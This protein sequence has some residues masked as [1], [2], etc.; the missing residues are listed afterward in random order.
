MSRLGELENAIV[1]RLAGAQIGGEDAFAVVR[2]ESGGFRAALRDT[3][4][5]ERLPM[6][7]VAFV[8]EPHAPEVK[9]TVRGPRF[10]VLIAARSLR[11]TSDPR[12]GDDDATGA[13]ALLDAARARLDDH[14]IETGRRLVCIHERFV[15][16]D[17]RMAVYELLYRGTPAVEE[18]SQ[19][20]LTFDGNEIAGS[21][22]VMTLE[23]GALGAEEIDVAFHDGAAIHRRKLTGVNTLVWRGS[24]RAETHDDLNGIEDDLADLISS[25][26]VGD[27]EEANVRTFADC[28]PTALF[29]RGPRAIDGDGLVTQAAEL[30]FTY[31]P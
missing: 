2:G 5:R 29:R 10:V 15:E 13:F 25:A 1:N 30:W 20:V 6:A 27:V 12:H 28:T 17:E 24:L 23:A 18:A 21:D 31:S 3:L 11:T 19:P 14:E 7:A 22:S 26:A 8:D 4:A 9:A 16:A